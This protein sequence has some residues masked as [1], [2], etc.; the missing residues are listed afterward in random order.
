MNLSSNDLAII[1]QALRD[2]IN[3]GYD[4]QV[5]MNYRSVLSKLQGFPTQHEG[6]MVEAGEP[7]DGFRYDHDDNSM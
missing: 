1:E 2:G 6:L 3:H 4:Y 5:M 7:K